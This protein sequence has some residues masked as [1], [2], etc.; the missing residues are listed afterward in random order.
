MPENLNK[1]IVIGLLGVLLWSTA[2][3]SLTFFSS[4]DNV[5]EDYEINE[6]YFE[7]VQNSPR[8]GAQSQTRSARDKV[9]GPL[10]LVKNTGFSQKTDWTL[11]NATQ[12]YPVQN[13]SM[14]RTLTTYDPWIG[15]PE[16]IMFVR[17]ANPTVPEVP[18]DDNPKPA[19]KARINQTIYKPAETLIHP[20]A[21]VCAFHYTLFEFNNWINN[22]VIYGDILIEMKNLTTN[23]AGVWPIEYG[24]VPPNV[25]GNGSFNNGDP[26]EDV[27]QF[28][29]ANVGGNPL[30]TIPSSGSFDNSAPGN[31]EISLIFQIRT[32]STA[33]IS[34][35]S[36]IATSYQLAVDNV[37]LYINDK[38]VPLVVPNKNLYGPYNNDS[39]NDPVDGM[40]DV[41]FFAGTAGTFQNTSIKVAKYRLSNTTPGP[42]HS[43][44]TNQDSYT[45]DWS[46]EDEWVNLDEGANTLDIYCE[47]QVGNYNDSVQI[48]VIKDTR[49]PITHASELPEYTWG[50]ETD[51]YYAA[52]DPGLGDNTSGG[53]NN[54]VKLLFRYNEQGEYINYTPPSAPS[55]LF[56]ESPIIFNITDAGSGYD[57]GKYE[58]YTIGIDNTSN[59][60]DAPALTNPDTYTTF[61]YHLPVS[62][63]FIDG[64]PQ[65]VATK[66]FDVEYNAVD[67][68]SGINHTELWYEVN[69]V[70]YRWNSSGGDGNFMSSP[71]TFTAESDGIYGFLTVAYDKLGMVEKNGTPDLYPTA[72][73]DFT[74]QVDSEPPSPYFTR[75]VKEHI[76]GK[77]ILTVESDF[78]TQY[79]NMSYWLDL[80]G[81]GIADGDDINS[82]WNNIVELDI[83]DMIEEVNWSYNWDTTLLTDF[84]NKEHMVVLRAIG[85][86]KTFKEGIGLK[87]LE[88]DN[89]PPTINITNPKENSAENNP[90]VII[91]YTTPTD[92]VYANVYYREKDETTWY[93]VAQE[94]PHDYGNMNGSYEWVLDEEFR[95]ESH[96]V[97]VKVEA[98]DDA[99]NMGENIVTFWI[100][101]K[102]PQID[103]VNFPKYIEWDEDFG[104]KTQ[105]L[106]AY[107]SHESEDADNLKWYV[108]GNTETIFYLTG[109]LSTGEDADT[110]VYRSIPNQHGTEILTFHLIDS[111]EL[112]DTITQ[113]VVIKSVN[114][115][116]LLSLPGEP[117]HVTHSIEDVIDFSI[118]IS[119]VDNAQTD[120][121][122]STNDPTYITPD[123][124]N[125][126]FN[127][128]AEMNDQTKEIK[129]TVTDGIDTTEG[130][131]NIKITDNHRPKWIQKFPELELK[132][133][134]RKNN[135]LD[136]DEY[137]T[138]DDGDT[139]TYTYYG[140]EIIEITINSENQVTFKAEPNIKGLE[141]VYFRA[142]DHLGGFVD[143][144][145]FITL[146]DIND[147][148]SIKPIPDIYVHFTTGMYLGYN[149]DFSYF[150][151]DPDNDRSEL[152]IWVVT[153]LQDDDESWIEIHPNYNLW[154]IFR[155]PF[156]AVGSHPLVLYVK[157][158]DQATN[159]TFF[160]VIVVDSFPVEQ[161]RPLPEVSFEEPPGKGEKQNAFNLDTYFDNEDESGEEYEVLDNPDYKVTAVI[162]DE[163]NVDL[164]HINDDW[165]GD[166]E[167]VIRV[168]DIN[169]DQYVYALFIVHVTPV[170]DLPEFVGLPIP[171]IK[172]NVSEERVLDLSEYIDDVETPKANLKIETSDKENVKLIT[173]SQSIN[174]KYDKAGK[175]SFDIT[176]IDSD[177]GSSSMNITVEVLKKKDAEPTDMS[178]LIYGI[179]AL[180]IIIIVIL[181]VIMITFGTYKV[182]EVFLIHQ[183][184]ILLT[185]LSHERT[186]ERDEEILSGMFTAVQEFIKDSFT[187]SK[188]TT[189]KTDEEYVLKEMKIGEN[190]NILIERGKYVY[191]A[192][193]FS[194]RGAGKLRT[195]AKSVLDSVEAKY[196]HAFKTWVGDM[197]KIRGIEKL[198]Q[199]LIPTGTPMVTDKQLGRVPPPKTIAVEPVTATPAAAK[200]AMPAQPAQVTAASIPTA[201]PMTTAAPAGVPTAAP[202]T[203]AAAP[204]PAKPAEPAAAVSAKPA[205]AAPAAEG[206]MKCPKCGADVNKFSD[207]SVSCTKCDY[208][209]TDT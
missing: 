180:I 39:H 20:T 93:L 149:Y 9:M 160:N 141:I 59:I 74:L 182:K 150:I 152:S 190:N 154:L 103:K 167:I 139:L 87:S 164:F 168:K 36:E 145:M 174:I 184:G 120:L 188:S 112:E 193:I 57:E 24:N 181:A 67:T 118:Y 135:Y 207:G 32:P 3:N 185:H 177:G 79:V 122:L 138:D 143:G 107:E 96:N 50:K 169:P 1:I 151:S 187:T 194:G 205:T 98:I 176:V 200:P 70:W 14:V 68:G 34:D 159:Y 208:T 33:S 41:D 38:D 82:K 86:D 172:I 48:T 81:D 199:P 17:S 22:S 147:P 192:V 23:I 196:E 197:D 209:G 42:W 18:F 108:T 126:S 6:N 54:T 44:C 125:L 90:S 204:A 114:D 29:I 171:T 100:S 124:L 99:G 4:P 146:K 105:K 136:L 61:D 195:K 163:N 31:Y 179:I 47:D 166:E 11:I 183:S 97:E 37:T 162:D 142:K 25:Y 121:I 170:N 10:Q 127:Y 161:D 52:T 55:G 206:A 7:P 133:G 130:F 201:A 119:D 58:F 91:N 132:A 71:I 89:K 140:T 49:K 129:L 128:P 28:I 101:I 116:P 40:I 189:G 62:N 158:P 92:V 12:V 8:S 69:N 198:L 83:D 137:F 111:Q 115:K 94:V 66:T 35:N 63:A 64:N 53:F 123:G 76:R 131:I 26:R 80:D 78:D 175:H 45:D 51:I 21:F 165:Y 19:L 104:K 2:A 85:G 30:W 60:E 5:N 15:T 27:E 77:E 88:V 203:P 156:S 65:T 134:E 186:Q 84:A 46:I 75:P 157:D 113:T 110:F 202:I 153:Q 43:I 148:P 191:L 144:Y 73:P 178:I 16:R 106:T 95:S 56:N 173:G 155:F 117:F 109:D 102:G 13:P 72:V